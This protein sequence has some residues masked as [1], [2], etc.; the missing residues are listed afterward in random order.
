MS[1]WV[2][3][4]RA[5]EFGPGMRVAVDVDDT[6]ILV[7]N[8]DGEYYAIENMCTH[9]Q[10]ALVDGELSGT[11]LTCPAHDARFCV[12]T[13]E[14]LCAPAYEPVA[15]FPVRIQDGMVQTRDH[16]WD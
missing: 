1:D 13:G 9:E 8:I 11:E 5:A 2:N 14:A 15:T 12:K 7:F 10:V 4:E 16:R 3:V 6:E